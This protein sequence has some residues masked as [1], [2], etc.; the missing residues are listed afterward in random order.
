MNRGKG[1]AGRPESQ[2]VRCDP[3]VFACASHTPRTC[4]TAA[5]HS[6]RSLLEMGPQ[7]PTPGEFA[8]DWSTVRA[9]TQDAT[10]RWAP[11]G[12]EHP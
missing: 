11:I 10:A 1:E 3:K 7:R 9:A 12:S 6:L 8:D 2:D 4:K 5:M